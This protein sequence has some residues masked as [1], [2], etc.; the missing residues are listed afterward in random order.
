MTSIAIWWIRRDFRLID[1]QA[2]SAA[3]SFADSVLPIFI[4]DPVLQQR[5]APRKK[6]YLNG[7]IHGLSQTIAEQGG[8]LLILQGEPVQVLS[9]LVQEI[10]AVGVFAEADV[11][12]YA[13]KRDAEIQDLLPLQLTAG[14]TAIPSDVVLKADGTPYTV[15]TPFSKA[16]KQKPQPAAV[17]K[18]PSVKWT[19][20]DPVESLPIPDSEPRFAAKALERLIRFTEKR[21]YQYKETRDRV[22]LIGTSGLSPAFHFGLISASQAVSLAWKAIEE[23]ENLIHRKNAET[24]LNEL[25]WRE[26]YNSI[27]YHFP[28]VRNKAF[29]EKYRGIEWINDPV[30]LAA[31][32]QGMTGYPIVDAAMRQMNKTG[33][34]HNRARMIAA[35]FL[36]KD[37]LI[38]WKQGEEYFMQRL[39]DGDVASNNGGWQWIAGVGTDAAPYFRIFNPVLQS[40]KFDPAGNYIRKYIPE[41]ADLPSKFIHEPWK[42]SGLEQKKYGVK[43]GEIYPL[44]IIDHQYARQRTLE[45]YKS[46]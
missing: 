15:Y 24:W 28:V 16:W 45:A 37:L 13:R 25:I 35:S 20:I 19:K 36:V 22:D 38:D 11:T 7:L 9:Q 27:L 32:Q 6:A 34:M 23:T 44:P 40:K 14:L 8:S 46:I 42:M 10:G 17:F 31:W 41:L 3:I 12:P 1:N 2:L 21:I 39:I 30:G 18:A 43:L 33:W 4:Q 26:F 29:R 5:E